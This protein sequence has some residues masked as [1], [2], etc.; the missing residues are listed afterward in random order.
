VAILSGLSGLGLSHD[1][2]AIIPMASSKLN[3]KASFAVDASV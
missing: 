3:K 1:I 2:Y